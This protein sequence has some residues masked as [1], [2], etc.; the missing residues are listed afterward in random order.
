LPGESETASATASRQVVV[1]DEPLQAEDADVEYRPEDPVLSFTNYAVGFHFATS[2]NPSES[3]DH[4]TSEEA[5]A[6]LEARALESF[7]RDMLLYA[8]RH[9]APLHTRSIGPHQGEPVDVV[10]PHELYFESEG[11]PIRLVCAEDGERVRH[12]IVLA[13]RTSFARSDVAVMTLV[14]GSTR[15]RTSEFNEYDLIKLAKLWEGGERLPEPGSR[16]ES[17]YPVWF[18]VDGRRDTLK[19]FAGRFLPHDS[20][21]LPYHSEHLAAAMRDPASETRARDEDPT[22][23]YRVGTIALRLPATRENRQLFA[24]AQAIKELSDDVPKDGTRRWKRVRAVGGLLQGL[25][26]FETI[27]PTELSDVFAETDLEEDSLLAFHKGTL[28]SVALQGSPHDDA[29]E[30]DLARPIGISPYLVIPHA[31]LLYNEQ[32]LKWA[33]IRTNELLSGQGG[34][35]FVAIGRDL[36]LDLPRRAPRRSRE[37]AAEP[38]S[39]GGRRVSIEETEEGVREIAQ[40]VA[41][42]LPNVF[43][44]RSERELYE[45]GSES[46]GFSDFEPLI[47]SRLEELK[48]R[49]AARVHQRETWTFGLT[50]AFFAIAALQLALK[51]AAVWIS[52]LLLAVLGVLWWQIRKKAF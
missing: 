44:Y 7:E 42:H 16:D 17:D 11:E 18:E 10:F 26:D 47:R 34:A 41:Q 3:G 46:R 15:S 5:A 13:S 6:T 33:L 12:A 48:D 40:A 49:L 9:V 28:L 24:D 39:D 23:H 2:A 43:H 25:L 45:R 51:S 29:R 50:L 37:R 4:G 21:F 36:L 22:R 20:E 19:I 1:A 8:Y 32:R 52:L 38:P 14:L 35:G 27:G 30:A 31:V